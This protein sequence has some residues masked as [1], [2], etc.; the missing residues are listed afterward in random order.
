MER[1]V[2]HIDKKDWKQDLKA[3]SKEHGEALKQLIENDK[4]H[5]PNQAAYESGGAISP[6]SRPRNGRS[7]TRGS[8]PKKRMASIRFSP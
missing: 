4:N 8:W 1:R 7:W 3:F 2:L 6:P 5:W